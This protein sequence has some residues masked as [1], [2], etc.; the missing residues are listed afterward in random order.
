[1]PVARSTPRLLGLVA[2]LALMLSACGN[3]APAPRPPTDEAKIRRTVL[4]WYSAL[5]RADGRRLCTLLT[6]AARKAAAE[7]GPNVV[8]DNGEVR[9]IAATCSA[10]VA[11]QARSSVVDEGI[12][13]GVSHAEVRRVDVLSDHANATTRVGKGEQIMALT[14]FGSQW[15]VSGFP[16]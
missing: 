13:P 9:R 2:A 14:K 16:Q 7:E 6:P 5:A 15:L 3:N 8:I 4:A 11:R 12:A 1:M 10:R